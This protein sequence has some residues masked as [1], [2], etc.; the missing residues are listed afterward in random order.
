MFASVALVARRT[1]IAL[2]L[3]LLGVP[4]GCGGSGENSAA[5]QPAPSQATPTSLPESPSSTTRVEMSTTPA[6]QAFD[7]SSFEAIGP[8]VTLLAATTPAGE[9]ELTLAAL[10]TNSPRAASLGRYIPSNGLIA[11]LVQLDG[12]CAWFVASASAEIAVGESAGT[13]A[14]ETAPLSFNLDGAGFAFK[15][16]AMSWID[17]IAQANAETV[18]L[19][20]RKL[21]LIEG[22]E[23]PTVAD[24][25]PRTPGFEY[26]TTSPSARTVAI[27]I[28]GNQV[29]IAV[30]A[31][32]GTCYVLAGDYGTTSDMKYGLGD[33]C[34][35]EG[36]RRDAT[37][38]RFPP[39]TG[40]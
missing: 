40:A 10:A 25:A 35:P 15:D 16:A 36:A 32:S 20:L 17:G 21:R 7:R 6:R 22:L 13:C 4:T 27:G 39:A 9:Q 12:S 14:E 18:L 2:A 33:D 34:T 3:A 1:L 30:L 31:Q 29:A 38:D 23:Q 19:Q 26:G 28:D 24:L 37:L 5:I 8:L 11:T